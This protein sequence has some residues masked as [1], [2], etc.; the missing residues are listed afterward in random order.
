MTGICL[1]FLLRP[2]SSS[3]KVPTD[4]DSL[5]D[6]S[7]EPIFG[8]F[9]TF[10]M[11]SA[12]VN[13]YNPTKNNRL[14]STVRGDQWIYISNQ[15]KNAIKSGKNALIR[16]LC[17]QNRYFS[18]VYFGYQINCPVETFYS[19]APGNPGWPQKRSIYIGRPPSSRVRS[20]WYFMYIDWWLV[21]YV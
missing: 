2:D 11:Y 14:Y 19:P 16:K 17:C 8:S 13:S 9:K 5:A 12:M 10:V 6:Q 4:S 20:K 15:T 1:K 3:I 18:F 7:L 21:I